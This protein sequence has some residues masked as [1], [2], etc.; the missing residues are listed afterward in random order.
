MLKPV[1]GVAAVGIL[2]FLLLPLL[3]TLLGVAFFFVKVALV[4]GAIWFVFRL[5]RKHSGDEK[6]AGDEAH[7]D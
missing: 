2:G 5:F 7:A 1:I 3:G 6:R 4:V